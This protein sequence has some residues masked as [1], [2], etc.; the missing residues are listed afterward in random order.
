MI[1]LV[2]A[3]V[4]RVAELE[5]LFVSLD[6]QSYRDFEVIVV[7]QNPDDRLL[8]VL[9]QHTDLAILHLRSGR[10]LSHARNV[11]LLAAQGDILAVPDDD[12]WYPEQLLHCVSTWLPRILNPM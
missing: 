8:P 11:G 7:D 9:Q 5:R 4:D 3:T 1:S 6:A 10:G 12:C 2:V